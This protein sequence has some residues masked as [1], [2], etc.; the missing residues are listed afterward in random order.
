MPKSILRS[1]AYGKILSAILDGRIAPGSS[2][3]EEHLA[4]E[5]AVSRTPIRE[6]LHKLAEEGFVVY[7][8]HRGARLLEPSA[9]LACEVF[10]IR[11]GLEAIAARE[12]AQKIDGKVL[13]ELRAHFL[14]LRPRIRGGDLSDVGDELHAAIL[15]AC[16][17]ARLVSMLGILH[18]QIRWLQTIAVSIP[19]RPARAYREHLQ[20]L[21]A[22]EARD[23][24][25]AENAIRAHIRSTLADLL[26][27]FRTQARQS[28]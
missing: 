6:A 23:P 11:E 15:Q 10:Q 5:F 7:L 8:P 21:T 20:I 17:N 14:S 28:R 12:A 22:L 26:L 18:G 3:R 9:E 25:S 24:Q 19:T 16:G 13:A 1:D 27:A 4:A 2:L